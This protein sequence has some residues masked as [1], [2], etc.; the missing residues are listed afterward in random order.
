METRHYARITLRG[1]G[2][3]LLAPKKLPIEISKYQI[4]DQKQAGHLRH[5]H[6]LASQP[7]GDWSFMGAAEPAQ[8]G[9]IFTITPRFMVPESSRAYVKIGMAR[10]LSIAASDNGLRNGCC[11][12]PSSSSSSKSTQGLVQPAYR[13]DA[14]KR[15]LGL[16]VPDFTKRY[17]NKS[18]YQRIEEAMGRYS[19]QGEHHGTYPLLVSLP[20]L[21][22][23]PSAF[24]KHPNIVECFSVFWPFTFDDITLCDALR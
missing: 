20:V 17:L 12:L 22:L 6:N 10:R 9:Y 3:R 2:D 5:F 24:Y 1:S 18:R 11:S 21:L 4:L 15:C 14:Q 23:L 7:A 19:N 8:A 13:K 16:L